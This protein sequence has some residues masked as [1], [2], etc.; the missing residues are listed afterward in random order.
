M[1]RPKQQILVSVFAVMEFLTK[2][3]YL[4]CNLGVQSISQDIT[5]Y[6]RFGCINM[7]YDWEGPSFLFVFFHHRVYLF[8]SCDLQ[9]LLCCCW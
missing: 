3:W 6:S 2:I 1:F 5:D 9:K 4:D 8:Y 7:A